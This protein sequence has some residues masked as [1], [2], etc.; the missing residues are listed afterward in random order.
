MDLEA[1][2]F[3]WAGKRVL[4]TAAS[5]GVGAQLSGCGFEGVGYAVAF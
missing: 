4:V 2:K 3:A 1:T 5:G